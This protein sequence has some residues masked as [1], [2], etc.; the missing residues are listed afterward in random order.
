MSAYN[1][2]FSE[3]LK[4]GFT[5]ASGGT[6]GPGHAS[7][8]SSLRLYGRGALEWGEA[9]DEDLLRLA[10]NFASASPP[11]S[12]IPGQFWVETQFY[13][14][15]TT[16]VG[17]IQY[18]WY[19]FIPATTTPVVAAHWEQIGVAGFVPATIPV[20]PVEGQSYYFD[21]M[22]HGYYSLG[23]YEPLGWVTRS[24]STGVGTPTTQRPAQFLRI[25]DNNDTGLWVTPSAVLSSDTA[26]DV[27][28]RARGI[29]WFDTTD[30]HLKIWS[31][32][33]WQD[34]LGPTAG[35]SMQA[36]GPVDM[37]GSKITSLGTPTSGSD[38]TNKTYVDTLVSTGYLPLSGGTI[39][40]NLTVTG[41]TSLNTV[42]SSGLASF[43]TLS[44]TGSASIGGTLDM[45]SLGIVNLATPTSPNDAANKTYVDNLVTTEYLPLSGGT[46]T[47]N[48]T[49]T[50]TTTANNLNSSG[51]AAL[52]TLT[53]SG[54]SVMSN[55][56]N[57]SNKKIINV[58][59][60]TAG[61]DAANK[62]YVDTHS[63]LPV[64]SVIMWPSVTIPPGFLECNGQA[65]SQ[66]TYSALFAVIGLNYSFVGFPNFNVPDFR[67]VFPRGWD[68][69]RGVDPS[70]GIGSQQGDALQNIIGFWGVDDRIT[71]GGGN[72]ATA[73]AVRCNGA[74]TAAALAAGAPGVDTTASG[75]DSQTHYAEFNASWST[76]ARTSTETRPINL[77][78]VFIIKY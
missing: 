26:P 73:G 44:V 76:G 30:G 25:R 54:A 2:D 38:A 18:G 12:A 66:S 7:S 58:D 56:L 78:I 57:M 49:I 63:T 43:A 23:K 51:V 72:G 21:G 20:S 5:I 70:R 53:V 62:T 15:D 9:V 11:S 74:T 67:G 37:N 31:G 35:S 68:H 42:S 47:G 64:G 6:N 4:A 33:S 77:S 22:L 1:I 14:R 16:A 39:A 69:G 28:T 8:D 10:E 24:F 61:G 17:G 55:Q 3:P 27:N 48:L 34:I 65:I 32:T 50:G 29:L 36:N 45:N 75:G 52:T 60:P 71:S 13:Y 59:V 40:G 41:N 46:I 19:R